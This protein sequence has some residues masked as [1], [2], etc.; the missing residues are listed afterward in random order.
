[1]V[2]VS[3]E[4]SA[5]PCPLTCRVAVLD[6]PVKFAATSIKMLE[7]SPVPATGPVPPPS[8]S[9]VIQA[10][11]DEIDQVPVLGVTSTASI[12]LL[13]PSGNAA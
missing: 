3:I 7:V 1:M 9:K 12:T 4:P 11:S 6:A 13:S 10:E 8:S 2:T 5:V